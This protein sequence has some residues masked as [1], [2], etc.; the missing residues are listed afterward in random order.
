MK[1][2]FDRIVVAM[3]VSAG[4]RS[5]LRRAA[6]LARQWQAELAGLFVEDEN[7]VRLAGLPFAREL[8]VGGGPGRTLSSEAV[9]REMAEAAERLER[10]IGRVAGELG[11]RWSFA[12]R[13]GRIASELVASCADRELLV[14]GAAAARSGGTRLGSTS[15][16]LLARTEVPL[17]LT[18]PGCGAPGE[19]VTVFDASAA[20]RL[21]LRV[22]QEMVSD[23][24]PV[25]VLIPAADDAQLAR[26]ER[27]AARASGARLIRV[28]ALAADPGALIE[29][30]AKHPGCT[31][32][33]SD[34]PWLDA[35]STARLARGL[36]GVLVRV[37]PTT[38]P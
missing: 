7:L 23:P 13:R 30:A 35:E 32:V 16:A 4:S 26:R 25:R 36:D 9:E 21:A 15:R 10:E 11:V 29:A 6:T 18:R 31:L 37:R 1:R 17:M 24:K 19:T 2:T 22:A 5:A 12:T 27:A 38:A 3:D 34:L 33:L 8:S 14:L 20:S 28:Q